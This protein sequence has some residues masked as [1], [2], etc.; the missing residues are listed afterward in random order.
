MT[1]LIRAVRR[2]VRRWFGDPPDPAWHAQTPVPRFTGYDPDLAR[3]G[4]QRARERA[5][6]IRRAHDGP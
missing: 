1:R 4:V 6:R 3:A 5:S 2:L